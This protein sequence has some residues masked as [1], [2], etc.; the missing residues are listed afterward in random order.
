[1][2]KIFAHILTFSAAICLA[3]VSGF[4]QNGDRD[5]GVELNK[6][7]TGP[8]AEGVY[9][10]NLEAYATGESVV[11][12]VETHMPT[13]VVLVLDMSLSMDNTMESYTYT[14]TARSSQGYSYNDI[15]WNDYYILH[16]DGNYYEA[17]VLNEGGL[18][19]LIT[20]APKCYLYYIV[21]GTRYYLYGSSGA[22]TT[23]KPSAVKSFYDTIWTG[24]LYS[25]TRHTSTTTKEQALKSA[26]SS[27]VDVLAADAKAYDV[28]HKVAV[29]QYSNDQYYPSDSQSTTE[30]SRSGYT[31]I[32]KNLVDVRN[33]SNVTAIKTAVNGLDPSGDTASD[34]GMVKAGVIFPNPV[35]GRQQVVIMFTDGVPNHGGNPLSE[36]VANAT[37]ANSKVLKN[38]GVL[39]YTIGIFDDPADNVKRYMNAV[40]SNYPNATKYT[41]G[42]TNIHDYFKNATDAD[43][44]NEIFKTIAQESAT[45]GSSTKLGSES[46][47]VLDV[48]SVNFSLPEGTDRDDIGMFVDEVISGS[49]N[50]DEYTYEFGNRTDLVPDGGNLEEY[51]N[52]TT[53]DGKQSISVTGF[54]FTK[55]DTDSEYGNWVGPRTTSGGG[56]ST[57]VYKGKRLVITIPVVKV[58]GYDGGY[59]IETN[60]SD[61]GI[62]SDGKKVDEFPVP[63]L[64]FPSL[65]VVKSGLKKGESAMFEIHL[66]HEVLR[67]A[68]GNIQKDANG[69]AMVKSETAQ[70]KPYYTLVVTGDGTNNPQYA[71]LKNIEEGEYTVTE[72]SWSWAY[73]PTPES[74]EEAKVLCEK[75]VSDWPSGITE[76]SKCVIFTFNNT[77]KSNLPDHAESVVVNTFKGAG[78][79]TTSA[80]TTNSKEQP[81]D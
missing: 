14:Y 18:G 22:G 24:V 27:F 81:A 5:S 78:V 69:Y 72:T 39:V 54:D 1:M 51:V 43:E 32:V 74:Y 66:T 45:G 30:S 17:E 33:A 19:G 58:D 40:S 29:V 56:S 73:T 25:R 52:F 8:D 34:Y 57:T 21:D 55:A 7:V 79:T 36:S 53:T 71:I 11:S 10:I 70:N 35:E 68:D 3:S 63:T 31:T 37:T 38:K 9:T 67:D 48:L 62:Y 75:A 49:K 12:I 77:E 44:L 50:G 80:V 26:V 23:T 2:K 42:D 16:S 47:V 28:D 59:G 76:T 20:G 65:A 46:T 61:S 6:Y 41:E 64:D 13:D 4:A 60:T 15:R